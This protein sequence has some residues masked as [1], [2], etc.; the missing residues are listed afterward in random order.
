M[1]SKNSS[2]KLTLKQQDEWE[3]YFNENKN[4]YKKLEEEINKKDME[5][6]EIVF[7]LYEISEQERKII[8]ENILIR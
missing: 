2:V 5:I 6:D 8:E 3:E 4:K 7:S 1:I